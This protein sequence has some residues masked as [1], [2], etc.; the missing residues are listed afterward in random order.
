MSV[1]GSGDK[2]EV[3]DSCLTEPCRL[4]GQDA[5][6]VQLTLVIS[7]MQDGTASTLAPVHETLTHPERNPPR[8]G[9]S[10]SS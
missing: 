1:P 9:K 5:R 3:R 10:E 6:T 4:P 2:G 8:K 7:A